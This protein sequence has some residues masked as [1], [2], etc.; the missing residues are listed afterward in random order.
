MIFDAL[1][2][3]C[4][5]RAPPSAANY[6]WGSVLALMLAR[7]RRERLVALPTIR[8]SVVQ[9]TRNMGTFDRGLRAFVVAPVAIVVA[10]LLGAGT[11][12]GVAGVML[13]TAVTAFC[14]TYTLVGMS[15]R[16]RLHRVRH[17]LR[18]G[19]A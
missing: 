8:R 4:A 11:V 14:P 5:T 13:T 12:F 16:P 1:S 17:G 7:Q 15:T 10:L 19:H 9:V 6:G 3:A 18:A 2:R